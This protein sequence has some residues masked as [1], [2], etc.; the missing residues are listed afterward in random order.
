MHKYLR[1]IGF[2]NIKTTDQLFN[3]EREVI[4]DCDRR[5]YASKSLQISTVQIEK[6]YGD[7]IGLSVV[8]ETMADNRFIPEHIFPFIRPGSYIKSEPVRVIPHNDK[9]AYSGLIED[10]NMTT[11]FYIQNISEYVRLTYNNKDMPINAVCFSGLSLQGTILIPLQKTEEEI[12]DEKNSLR[13][14][15]NLLRKARNGDEEAVNQLIIK[16]MDIKNDIMKRVQNEDILSIVDSSLIPYGVDCE[17]YE[18][19]GNIINV[20]NVT[21]TDTKEDIYVLDV[22]ANGYIIRIAINKKDLIGVPYIGRRFRGSIWLQGYL[23][24]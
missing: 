13:E 15:N 7:E 20:K 2:S 18:I 1:A 8:G 24:M 22:I 9:E 10:I 23:L 5:D 6:D 12:L 19:L 17:N 11:I 21:N 16:D 3:M 14:T 4:R